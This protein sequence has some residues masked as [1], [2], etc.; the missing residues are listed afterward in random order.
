MLRIY[1]YGVAKFGLNQAD[2]YYNMF[3]DCFEKISSNPH[4]F[5]EA[6]HFRKGYSYCVCGADTI[7]Y[8]INGNEIEIMAII[9]RQDF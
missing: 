1:E 2:K 4:L 8:K 7:Y 3:Q 5:P 6:N 9:G